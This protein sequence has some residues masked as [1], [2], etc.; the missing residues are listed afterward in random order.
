[1]NHTAPSFSASKP[2]SAVHPVATRPA[3][4]ASTSGAFESLLVATDFSEQSRRALHVACDLATHYGSRLT[5]LHVFPVPGYVLPE[6]FIAAGPEVLVEVENRSRATLETWKTE[7]LEAGATA[8]EIVTAIGNPGPEIVR[9]ART[10]R[11]SAIVVGTHGRTGLTGLILGSV[12]QKVV[13][14][15]E[16][17]VVTVPLRE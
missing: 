13:T 15:A 8:V 6:G 16:C 17:P 7:A 12:A 5:L 10:G 11:F 14:L 1:M 3:S 4:G 9:L 2:Q